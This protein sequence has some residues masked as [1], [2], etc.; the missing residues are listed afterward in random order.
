MVGALDSFV[1]LDFNGNPN[2]VDAA[3]CTVSDGIDYDATTLADFG[4]LT[5]LGDAPSAGPVQKVGRTT[6]ATEGTITSFELDGVAVEYD[7]GVAV[8][9]DVVE[10][11]SQWGPFSDGGDSGSLIVSSPDRRAVAL[12]FAGS[13]TGGLFGTGVTYAC[14]IRTV[15]SATGTELV[16]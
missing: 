10:I 11:A 15:L 2:A 3:V 9:D 8:F 5:G 14:P 13:A 16:T 7:E 1:P 12:L 4:A 6:A